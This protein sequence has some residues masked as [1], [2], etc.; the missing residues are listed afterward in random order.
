MF[1]IDDAIGA[2]AGLLG[3]VM[4]EIFG[5]GKREKAAQAWNDYINQAK[6][7]MSLDPQKALEFLQLTNRSAYQDMDPA[8]QNASMAAINQLVKRGSGTGLDV[9]SREALR[10]GIGQ[11]GG[12]ARAAREAALQSYQMRGTGGSGA[13]L[14]AALGGTQQAYGDLANATG[15]ASAAAEQRRLEANVLASR[16]G[17]QQQQLNQQ[18]AAAMDALRRFNVGARQDTLTNQMAAMRNLGT[19]YGGLAGVYAGQAQPTQSAWGNVGNM[20]GG[21]A[22]GMF[23]GGGNPSQT[24]NSWGNGDPG[25]SIFRNPDYTGQGEVW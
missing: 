4:G 13:E 9:Q 20:V 14:A 5:A 22:K 15:Q 3:G 1:G 7:Q 21:F 10:Q 6:G 23:N 8:A 24:V 25:G 2:G 19:G 17:Q 18:Q 12:A 16:A 11:A